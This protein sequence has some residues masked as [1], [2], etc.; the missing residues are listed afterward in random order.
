MQISRSVFDYAAPERRVGFELP[1]NILLGLIAVLTGIYVLQNALFFVYFSSLTGGENAA[2]PYGFPQGMAFLMGGLMFVILIA[3]IFLGVFV[4]RQV[5]AYRWRG[6]FTLVLVGLVRALHSIFGRRSPAT[7]GHPGEIAF[8]MVL[9][10]VA[11]L[12]YYM[13]Q[14]LWPELD[15]WGNP[16]R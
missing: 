11:G 2:S 4:F 9:L 13:M 5:R 16:H 12:A 10:C 8:T 14:K 6:Y 3:V 15:W 7:D 1:N